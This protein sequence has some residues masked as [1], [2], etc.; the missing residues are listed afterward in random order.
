MPNP[1]M[2]E[3]CDGNDPEKDC[4]TSLETTGR[5]LDHSLVAEPKLKVPPMDT[6]EPKLEPTPTVPNS[7]CSDDPVIQ[8]GVTSDVC[9]EPPSAL[10]KYLAQS[11][12]TISRGPD[13][14]EASQSPAYDLIED[15]SITA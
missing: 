7:S 2:R 4:Y 13:L 8:R 15:F 3:G 12:I 14:S 9:L 1:R 10:Q 6:N 5:H 11:L